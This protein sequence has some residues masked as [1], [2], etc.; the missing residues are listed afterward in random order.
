MFI[1]ALSNEFPAW[2]ECQ[3]S[4]IRSSTPPTLSQLYIDINDESHGL[5]CPNSSA[6]ETQALYSNKS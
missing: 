1:Q 3:R 4:T 2:A 6:L 5:T